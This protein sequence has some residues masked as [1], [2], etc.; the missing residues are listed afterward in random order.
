MEQKYHTVS[1]NTDAETDAQGREKL[2]GKSGKERSVGKITLDILRDNH[3]R[4]EH[5]F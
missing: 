4:A 2:M 3:I 5:P 1:I